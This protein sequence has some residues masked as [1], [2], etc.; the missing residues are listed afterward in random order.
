[1]SGIGKSMET[2]SDRQ[3]LGWGKGTGR[4]C[5]MGFPLELMKMFW[6][7]IEVIAAPTVWCLPLICTFTMVNFIQCEFYLE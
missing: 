2:E 5:F 4:D 6:D 7:W 3:R 1:M